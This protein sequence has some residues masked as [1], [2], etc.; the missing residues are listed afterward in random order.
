[1][2]EAHQVAP[3]AAHPLAGQGAGSPPTSEA[4]AHTGFHAGELLVQQRAG[5]VDDAARLGHMVE[6]S[7]LTEAHTRFLQGRTLA[8]VTARDAD[9]LLWI[10]PISGQPGFLEATSPA[11]LTIR[12]SPVPGD[13]LH[14]LTAPQPVGVL[15]IEPAN[16]RRIRVNGTLVH[17]D[18]ISMTIVVEQAYGNCPQ[19]IRRRSLVHHPLDN[20]PVAVRRG[21]L[22]ASDIEQIGA[23]DTFFLAPHIRHAATTPLTAAARPASCVSATATSSG[24]ITLATICSTAWATSPSTTPPRSCSVIWTAAE[25]CTFPSRDR[26]M[27]RLRRQRE[28]RHGTDRPLHARACGR[29]KDPHRPQR[30]MRSRPL[31]QAPVPAIGDAPKERRCADLGLGRPIGGRFSLDSQEKDRQKFRSASIQRACVTAPERARCSRFRA[32]GPAGW[33]CGGIRRRR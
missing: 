6:P 10:S 33:G 31:P 21:A 24:L 28:P 30:S 12:T 1:M 3:E 20:P 23:A 19:Y 7:E 2:T 11:E 14:G 13:P 29:R 8:L 22:D 27:G 26:R 4:T 15:V 18:D 25:R 9:G 17:A 16:R 32:Q 5:V